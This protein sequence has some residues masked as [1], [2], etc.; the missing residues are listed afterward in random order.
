[1]RWLEKLL[2]FIGILEILLGCLGTHLFLLLPSIFALQLLTSVPLA[3][4]VALLRFDCGAASLGLVSMIYWAQ[5]PPL[6]GF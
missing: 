1:M 2:F 3:L 4:Y 5:P 6:S